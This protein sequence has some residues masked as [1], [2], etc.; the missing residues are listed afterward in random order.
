[1]GLY[2]IVLLKC[3]NCG[4][5]NRFQTKSGPCEMREYLAEDAPS[6]VLMDINRHA[7]I[8]CQSCGQNY[9]AKIECNVSVSAVTF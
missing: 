8:E 5:E 1:M 6:N 4:Q 3:P 9:G 2:D 7:P